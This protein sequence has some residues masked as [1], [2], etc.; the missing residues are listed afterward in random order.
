MVDWVNEGRDPPPSIYPRI[1][2][3]TLVPSHLP[4]GE[5]NPLAWR[6]LTDINHPSQM[7]HVAHVNYGAGFLTRGVLDQLVGPV[8]YYR[9]LVPAIGVDNNELEEGA[10]LPPLTSVPLATFTSWNLR[11]AH[12]GA[13]KALARLMGG[14]IP[15]PATAGIAT[16]NGDH[17]PAISSLYNSFDEYLQAYEEATDALIQRGYLLPEFRQ[18]LIEIAQANRAIFPH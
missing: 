18:T 7:Y 8:Q 10:L 11:A 17:R 14:Y 6:A 4:D 3:G 5:I 1:D 2:N 12:T 15:L 16:Q 9:A 13:D